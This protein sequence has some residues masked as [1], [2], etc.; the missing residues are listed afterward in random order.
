MR[1]T[2]ERIKCFDA[3]DRSLEASTHLLIMVQGASFQRRQRFAYL[4]FVS[5]LTTNSVNVEAETILA[6]IGKTQLVKQ[7][8]NYS[9]HGTLLHTLEYKN[10]IKNFKGFRNV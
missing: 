4:L 3:F 5:K 8:Q 6:Y 1:F 7:F 2:L 9:T 10:S